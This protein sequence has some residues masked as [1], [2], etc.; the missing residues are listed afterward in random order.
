MGT[1]APFV[2][3]VSI[4]CTH[5]HMIKIKLEHGFGAFADLTS[6]A[7]FE[8]RLHDNTR[9]RYEP[10]G[11]QG[12]TGSKADRTSHSFIMW[13]RNVLTKSTNVACSAPD[14]I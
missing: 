8:T 7:T 6:Q 3:V 9:T 14:G 4:L 10:K 13:A 5:A 11:E 12:D 1:H 2:E